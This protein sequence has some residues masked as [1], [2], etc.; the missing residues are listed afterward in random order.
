MLVSLRPEALRCM[1]DGVFARIAI[2][3][4]KA[5]QKLAEDNQVNVIV[6]VGGGSPIDSA[7]VSS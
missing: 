7:K 1:V 6:S 2:K 5:A 3:Q 4:I